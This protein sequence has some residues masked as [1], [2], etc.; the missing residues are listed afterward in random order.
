MRKKYVV[1]IVAL[2]ILVVAYLIFSS[3]TSSENSDLIV[4]AKKGVFQ[5]DITT[6]GELEAKSSVKI[7]GPN[8][9][10]AGMWQVKIDKLVDEGTRVKKGDFIAGICL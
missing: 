6:S 5:I 1:P 7:M 2:L 10:S 3:S 8:F 9:M 4:E